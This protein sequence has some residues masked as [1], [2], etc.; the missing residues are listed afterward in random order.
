MVAV[1]DPS[2]FND[3]F[4]CEIAMDESIMQSR[5]I[6]ERLINNLKQHHIRLKPQDINRI[7]LADNFIS[8]FQ[9][10]AKQHGSKV[11]DKSTCVS[12]VQDVLEETKKLTNILCF[13]ENVESICMWSHYSYH[14]EGY[15]ISYNFTED[16]IANPIYPVVYTSKRPVIGG[17]QID[18][19]KNWIIPQLTCK[20]KQWEYEHEWRLILLV[21]DK[22]IL[23]DSSKRV[24]VNFN[25]F[26]DG[27]YLGAKI[28]Q[29]HERE[30]VEKYT[31]RQI[32][33]YKMKMCDSEYKLIPEQIQIDE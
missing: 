14:H 7:K 20:A 25:G 13:T 23:H 9:T 1:S 22:I 26:V 15:C 19:S 10:I 28:S 5:I 33:V 17:N 12:C 29:E 11:K 6:K 31:A 21:P 3:P 24:S 27:I 16:K 32:P 30:I 4:D 2:K 8:A 18:N